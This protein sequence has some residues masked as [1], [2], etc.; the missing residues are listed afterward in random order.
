[1]ASTPWADRSDLLAVLRRDLS[2]PGID[3]DALVDEEQATGVIAS[4]QA[5]VEARAAGRYDPADPPRLLIDIALD[6]A[7]YLLP[8]R[9]T[10]E[11]TELGDTTVIVRRYQRAQALLQAVYEGTAVL[12]PPDDPPVAAGSG[13]V[14]NPYDGL[15][16]DLSDYE[17]GRSR[18]HYLGVGRRGPRW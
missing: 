7:A 16:F 9:Y 2:Q 10:A 6:I 12:P 14:R 17:L 1:M 4:G 8:L 18:G 5:E 15:L 3:L 13:V 11:G